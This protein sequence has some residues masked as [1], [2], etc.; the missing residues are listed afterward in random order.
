MIFGSTWY[1][2]LDQYVV[3]KGKLIL[4]LIPLESKMEEAKNVYCKTGV[5]VRNLI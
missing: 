3:L 1:Y 2:Y 4:I 5:S